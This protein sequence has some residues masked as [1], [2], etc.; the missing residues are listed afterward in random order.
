MKEGRKRDGE[1]TGGRE[2]GREEWRKGGG[3][4]YSYALNEVMKSERK[5]VQG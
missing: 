5:T 1:G 3:G 4:Y 2:D